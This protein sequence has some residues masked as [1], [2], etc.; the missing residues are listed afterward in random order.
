MLSRIEVRAERKKASWPSMGWDKAITYQGLSCHLLG[1]SPWVRDGGRE[2]PDRREQGRTY[3][4]A[5][6]GKHEKNEKSP[7]STDD[8]SGSLQGSELH[9][10][11]P[12]LDRR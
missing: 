11:G 7:T 6:R 10:V 12:R 3:F 8:P 9:R 1:P 4:R 2:S 5:D